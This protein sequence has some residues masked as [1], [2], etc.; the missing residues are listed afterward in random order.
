MNNKKNFIWNFLGLSI[1]S[2]NSLFFLIIVNRIN[3]GNDGGI[4]TYAYSLVCLTYFIGLFFNRPY[5]IT[6]PDKYS[7]KENGEIVIQDKNNLVIKSDD[8]LIYLKKIKKEGKKLMEIKDYLNGEKE[9]FVGKICN[10][11]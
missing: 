2:F 4:F 8:G 6:N 1:N 7:N 3:G 10:R 5:Q 11:S 9:N